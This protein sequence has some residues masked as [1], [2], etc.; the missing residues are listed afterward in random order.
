MNNY[1]CIFLEAL[2]LTDE[3]SYPLS[4]HYMTL[5]HGGASVMIPMGQRWALYYWYK[6]CSVLPSH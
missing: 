3:S 4:S 1:Y 6:M 5:T 2:R